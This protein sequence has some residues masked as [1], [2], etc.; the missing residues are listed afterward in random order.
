MSSILK[1]AKQGETKTHLMYNCNLNYRQ[2]KEYEKLLLEIGFLEN[3][4][5]KITEKQTLRTTSKGSEFLR[6]YAELKILMNSGFS[7]ESP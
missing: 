7:R 6:K 3:H 2:F 5:S 4:F 1:K